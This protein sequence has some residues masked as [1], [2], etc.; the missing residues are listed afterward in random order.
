MFSKTFFSSLRQLVLQ[1]LIFL[2]IISR[3]IW[4]FTPWISLLTQHTLHLSSPYFYD[5]RSLLSIELVNFCILLYHLQ[6]N[7][8]NLNYD[9]MK[10]KLDFIIMNFNFMKVK[11][12]FIFMQLNFMKM[13]FINIS[14]FFRTILHLKYCNKNQ[15][16]SSV[17]SKLKFI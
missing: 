13:K 17:N 3:E 16:I 8:I 7:F 15:F 1:E 5:Y 6:L 10:I 12:N 2:K 9:F 11:L 14:N 4:V